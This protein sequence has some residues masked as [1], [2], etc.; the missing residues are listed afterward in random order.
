VENLKLWKSWSILNKFST[1]SC[2]KLYAQQRWHELIVFE[3]VE[4][5]WITDMALMF[6]HRFSTIG[7]KMSSRKKCRKIAAGSTGASGFSTGCGKVFHR[8]MACGNPWETCHF[9]CKI[10]I[11]NRH[12]L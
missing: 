6:F 9:K 2:G 3:A 10:D 12:N 5:L 8:S 11:R 1:G 4:N 7:I